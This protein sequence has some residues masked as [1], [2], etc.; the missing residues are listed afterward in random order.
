MI[1]SVAWVPR[2]CAAENPVKFE[3]TD[4]EVALARAEAEMSGLA[5]GGA[6]AAEEEGG[7][8]GGGE[9]SSS[10]NS[11]V[12]AI[13][14][15][16]T[17]TK[18]PPPPSV[19]SS[20]LPADLRMDDYDEEEDEDMSYAAFAHSVPRGDLPGIDEEE[21]E[22]DEDRT[23][24][25]DEEEDTRIKPSD[26]ILLAAHAEDEYS[27]LEVYV[28]DR[29][30]GS[31]F[32][33]HDV[34]LP[35]FPLA[36]AWMG[37]PPGVSVAQAGGAAGAADVPSGNFVAVGTFEPGIEI[38]NLDVLEALTP[39]ATLG[40]RETASEAKARVSSGGDSKKKKKKKKGKKKKSAG[41]LP[42]LRPG[43]HKDAVLALS[44]NP[45]Q[46]CVCV[47]VCCVSSVSVCDL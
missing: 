12:Q 13:P 32:V 33:H 23:M 7:G 40:G 5:L 45:M 8:G 38:W 41:L 43:S 46:R 39:T 34:A 35:A 20:G 3:P 44:W 11:S 37:H 47:V 28:Y 16:T 30:E 24:D 25:S 31:L 9:A 42:Q 14:Q 2:G 29:E 17:S 36:L 18:P 21:G 4:D 22:E 10:S 19:D 27:C 15:S 26:A 1:S 6:D